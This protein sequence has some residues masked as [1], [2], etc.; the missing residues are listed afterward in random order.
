MEEKIKM[1]KFIVSIIILFILIIFAIGGFFIYS[2]I[3]NNKSNDVQS[4]NEKCLS[5]INFLGTS[6]VSMMNGLN[7]ISYTNY[8]I[9]SE[10]INIANSNEGN[11]SS[12]QSGQET[13]N[14]GQSGQENGTDS[15]NT[16]N[17]SSVVSNNIL[18][19]DNNDVDWD[20]LKSEIENMYDSWTTI[21]IDLTTLNVNK[22]N[23]LKY[24]STMDQIAKDFD[25]Q[26]KSS[27]L[28]HLADLY[29][30]LALYMK[31]FAGNS[32]EANVYNVKSNIL[33]AYAHIET[34]DWNNVK[35]YV[36]SAKEAF[37]NILNNQVNNINSIDE[38]NKSY[39]LINELDED[40]NNQNKK[41]F[42][43]NYRNLMQELEN[44]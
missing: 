27:S 44:I 2:N 23:L 7:N 9:V 1:K 6:I 28:I 29:N 20:S 26:N 39:I 30:L 38:I 32:N 5:E 25:N 41:V 22:D 42:Y 3:M 11:S 18:S 14:S 13:S 35:K 12:S 17:S 40:C 37:S 19:E 24:N 10:E 31:D 43:V 8:R 16:I 15:Q 21:L 36:N 33:Y 4:L 34:D